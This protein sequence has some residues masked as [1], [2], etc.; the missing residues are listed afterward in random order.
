MTACAA[1]SNSGSQGDTSGNTVQCRIYH[2]G[3][4]GNPST[5]AVTHCPHAGPNGAGVCGGTPPAPAAT[6]ASAG[7]QVAA[8]LFSVV[9]MIAL[10]F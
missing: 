8:S 6:T 2:A 5:N 7:V 9:A 4:A 10:L 3:V 1:M